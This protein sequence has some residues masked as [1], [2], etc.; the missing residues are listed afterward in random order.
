M[1]RLTQ[2]ELAELVTVRRMEDIRYTLLQF[3]VCIVPQRV[4]EDMCAKTFNEMIWEFEKRN[5]SFIFDN[6][7]TWNSLEAFAPESNMIYRHWGFGQSQYVHDLRSDSCI[8]DC[9]ES[10]WETREL[11]CSFDAI[12]LHVPGELCNRDYFHKHDRYIFK[13]SPLNRGMQCIEGFVS[14]FDIC[15]GDA[16]M[17]FYLKSHQFFE[18]Y[19]QDLISDFTNRTGKTSK[20]D[21]QKAFTSNI[22]VVED[23]DFFNKR[24]CTEFRVQCP[25]GSVILWDSRTLHQASQPLVGRENPNILAGAYVCMVPVSRI[26]EYAYSKKIFIKR[27]LEAVENLR[28]TDHFPQYRIL[29]SLMPVSRLKKIVDPGF[30]YPNPPKLTG[31]AWQLATGVYSDADYKLL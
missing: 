9:F 14:L 7:K 5:S 24:G 12:A 25:S 16:T 21:I 10:V 15:D 23:L 2:R 29:E 4:N 18:R 6:L 27:S 8:I 3:G 30:W 20:E 17:S 13:Q 19:S 22:T 11:I 26:S 31:V 1:D 28:T